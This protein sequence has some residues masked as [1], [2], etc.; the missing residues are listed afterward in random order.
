MTSVSEEPIVALTSLSICSDPRSGQPVA[1]GPAVLRT[2]PPPVPRAAASA[3]P[4][5]DKLYDLSARAPWT[6]R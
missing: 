5:R 6:A 1:Q 3:P 2:G 4:L